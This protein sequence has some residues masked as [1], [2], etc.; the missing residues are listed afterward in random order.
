M[1]YTAIMV[2]IMKYAAY[3]FLCLTLTLVCLAALAACGKQTLPDRALSP[4]MGT[5]DDIRAF[6]QDLTVYAAAIGADR[7][8]LNAREQ[9]TQDA[10]FDRLFFAPWDMQKIPARR[11]DIAEIFHRPRG[12]R[13][14]GARWTR[15]QWDSIT[16]NANLAAFP[17]R[18]QPAI[19]LRTTDLRE[20]PTHEPRFSRPTPNPH[21]DPFDYF[22]YSLLPPGTPLLIGHTSR[23]GRWHFVETPAVGGWVDADDVGLVDDAFKRTWRVGRYAALVRDG[24]VLSEIS[25]KN[26]RQEA[27]IGT[28]LP[29]SGQTALQVLAPR[30]AAGGMAEITHATLAPGD[31]VVKPMPLTAGNI[32]RV[33][34]DMMGQPYGWGGMFSNRDC[35]ALTRDLFT[36]FGV[37]LPRNSSAQARFGLVRSLDALDSKEKE[38]ALLADG[39]PFLSLVGMRGHIA[40]Y[41]GNYKN[42]ALVFHNI[43]G[44][45]VVED[46]NDNS[47][48]VL[49]R[50]VVTSITPGREL[51]NLY[52]GAVF[53]DRIRTLSTLADQYR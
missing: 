46:G 28:I 7:P 3:R 2:G 26:G 27:G 47:R 31:A 48:F 25:G 17:S 36:P 19:T 40:L 49:G 53:A 8:L 29:L 4:W 38:S 50:A 9:A 41:L 45:R 15:A 10:R 11:K 32:A 39:A 18:A 21:A 33:G 20:M 23:D 34:N 14:G 51:K 30:K 12:Y 52:H 22:Q 24:V 6:P 35:S 16:T 1:A 42:R 13:Q 5:V 37:W 43:W 44:L